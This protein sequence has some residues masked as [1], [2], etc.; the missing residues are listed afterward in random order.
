LIEA[1][2]FTS[3]VFHPQLIAHPCPTFVTIEAEAEGETEADG[4]TEEYDDV[5]LAYEVVMF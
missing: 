2:P 3:I 4:V 5:E 1:A